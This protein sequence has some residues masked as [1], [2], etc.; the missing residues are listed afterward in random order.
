LAS[1]VQ[2]R[3]VEVIAEFAGRRPGPYAPDQPGRS[4][5]E[6]AADE[7]AAR[8]AITRRSDARPRNAGADRAPAQ[9]VSCSTLCP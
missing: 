8:L 3:Q 1:W 9:R 5:S 2:A 4:V 7:I 6:L